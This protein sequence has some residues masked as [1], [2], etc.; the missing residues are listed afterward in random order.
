MDLAL[1]FVSYW[2]NL[3]GAVIG[4]FGI[5]YLAGKG[6]IKLPF[7]DGPGKNYVLIFDPPPNLADIEK[8]L[9]FDTET[10]VQLPLIKPEDKN[11][12]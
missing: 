1:F 2:A 9:G 8:E 11:E 4:A 7:L 12:K 6:V 10:S 3:I 5:G